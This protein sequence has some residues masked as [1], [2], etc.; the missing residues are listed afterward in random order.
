VA[1]SDPVDQLLREY[2]AEH[3]AGRATNPRDYL[4]RL[5]QPE[6]RTELSALIDAYLV[7]A[8]RRQWDPAAFQESTRATALTDAL[9]RAISGESG[10]W[11]TLLPRLRRRAGIKRAELVR[12]LAAALGATGREEKVGL[13]YHQ[14]EQGLLPST[15]VSDRVLQALGAIVGERAAALR[16]AGESWSQGPASAGPAAPAFARRAAADEA[17]TP[18]EPAADRPEPLDD[19]DELFRGG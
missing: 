5:E 3:R 19:I 4:A 13:Y 15:G 6:Q 8:P 9:D 7:R 2:I 17:G 14:M 16:Q 12:R 11:P 1:M 18:H 10:T